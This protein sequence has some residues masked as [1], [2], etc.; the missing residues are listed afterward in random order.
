MT[1]EQIENALCD[2]WQQWCESQ[3]L[4]CLSADEMPYDDLSQEQRR[5]IHSFIMR[6]ESMLTEA[7]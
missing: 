1:N 4:E 3:G 2:E 6:W 7:E 5:Y